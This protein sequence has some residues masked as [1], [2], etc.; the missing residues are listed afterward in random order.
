MKSSAPTR[1]HLPEGQPTAGIELSRDTGNPTMDSGSAPEPL[2]LLAGG[3]AFERRLLE[4]ARVDRIPGASLEHLA[5]ALKVPGV[6]A[7]AA[8]LEGAVQASRFGKYGAL[9]GL[10][11]FGLVAAQVTLPWPS[12]AASEASAASGSSSSALITAH[13]TATL[14]PAASEVETA[15]LPP[16]LTSSAASVSTPAPSV[17]LRRPATRPRVGVS[18]SS[19]RAQASASKALT[20][21]PPA[22]GSG[23]L[24]AELRALEVIQSA[25][26]AGR[27]EEAGRALRDYER[28]FPQG[29]LALEAELLRVDVL[30]ARGHAGQARARARQLLAR[31]DAARYRARLEA[32]ANDGDPAVAPRAGVNPPRLHIE[33]RR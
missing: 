7:P 29:E 24:R 1:T 8:L 13:A 25:L 20:K 2:R 26:R 21:P 9:V 33:G 15:P 17:E 28:R 22:A 3:S 19:S 5:R 30:L 27:A 6:P 10:G 32:L 16:S 4:S 14:A 18:S 12:P 31:P 23:G 11:A